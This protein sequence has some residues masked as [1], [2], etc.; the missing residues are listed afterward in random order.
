MY[1]TKDAWIQTYTGRAFNV[2]TCKP[3]DVAI[4][5]IAHALSM[6]CRFAGHTRKFYS[7]GQ[8]SILVAS[9]LPDNLKLAGLLHDASE[10]YLVD[11]P[12]PIK[13]NMP[14]YQLIEKSVES[15]IAQAFN[16]PNPL[17]KEVKCAD[18]MLLCTEYNQLMGKIH[19]DFASFTYMPNGP[20]VLEIQ[21]WTPDQ[22]EETFLDMFYEL[23]G[24]NGTVQNV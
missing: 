18:S 16:L 1:T 20:S 13:Y 23:G 3:E 2:F 9:I 10:A 11:L 7:V 12:R 14:E 5:D 19:D 21:P 4:E 6:I 8:H 17:P 15:V 22:T 24:Y